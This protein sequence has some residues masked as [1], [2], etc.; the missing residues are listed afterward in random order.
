MTAAREQ[1]IL[2][3]LEAW[4]KRNPWA[5]RVASRKATELVPDR[6]HPAYRGSCRKFTQE[7]IK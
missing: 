4:S 5:A 6:Q 7:R 2:E 1:W 3:G